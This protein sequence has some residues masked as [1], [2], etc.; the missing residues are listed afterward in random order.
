MNTPKNQ[1]TNSFLELLSELD[2]EKKTSPQELKIINQDKIAT[3]STIM[4][5]ELAKIKQA[6][7]SI[8]RKDE[9]DPVSSAFVHMV[10]PEEVLSFRREGIQQYMLKKLKHGEY[11]E[12]DFIDLHGKTIEQ[13]YSY[14]LEFIKHCLTNEYR[15]CLIV[16][17]KSDRAKQ[18]AVLKSYVAHWLRQIPQ[19]LAYHSAPQFKGGTGA[20][21]V[22]LKKGEKASRENFERHAKR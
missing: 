1:S 4:D 18:K 16:H 10:D 13:A 20:L 8:H 14:T 5:K 9:S 7:A 17:G 22:I 3:Q 19:V 2:T 15:C 11:K 21:L 6:S 12:A